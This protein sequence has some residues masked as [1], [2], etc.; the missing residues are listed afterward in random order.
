M[1][2]LRL[3]INGREIKAKP[4]TTVLQAAQAS[5]IYIPTLC[6]DPD[7]KPHGGCRL[8]IIEVMGLRNM[9][10]ACTTEVCKDMVVNT[11]TEVVHRARRS[12]IDLIL[13][14]HPLD[15]L[16]CIKNQRCELQDVAAYLGITERN[17]P[18]TLNQRLIDDSNPFF[19][20]NHNYC[21]L[22]QRC[23]RTCDEITGVN[24]IEIINR[25]YNSKVSTFGDKPLMESICKSCGECVVHCPVAALVPKNNIIPTSK[26]ETTCPYCGVG[27]MMEIG[28]RNGKIVSVHGSRSSQAN[29]GRLCVKGRYGIADFVH[30]PERLTQPLLREN[31]KLK[32]TDWDEA[33]D[34][35][36]KK[37]SAYSGSQIAVIASA[38]CTNEENYV[39]QK[40]ARSVLGTNNIDHCARL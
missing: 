35:V 19:T 30:H 11:E 22:C 1:N 21:I 7:L 31:N 40:F 29:N 34:F 5:G 25:G 24:A 15:C 32:A 26:V 2:Y 37:L 18:G 6:A 27:C 33:L 36:A 8:C 38:K 23:T 20:F 17:L 13:A 16:T 9:V 39:V 4:G 3:K 28:V 10:T 14:D 12:V